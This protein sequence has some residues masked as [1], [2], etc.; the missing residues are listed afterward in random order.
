MRKRALKKRR[1][2]LRELLA[3]RREALG[4]LVLGM[5]VQGVWDDGLLARGAAEVR[6]VEDGLAELDPD[7]E[8]ADSDEEAGAA[9]RPG[10]KDATAETDREPEGRPAEP[11]GDEPPKKRGGRLWGKK[12]NGASDEDASTGQPE[13]GPDS[14]AAPHPEFE[15][16]EHTAEHRLPAESVPTPST[17][18]APE[19][20]ASETTDEGS[21]PAPPQVSGPKD[22]ASEPAGEPSP[23]PPTTSPAEPAKEP[24]IGPDGQ[25]SPEPE[26]TEAGHSAEPVGGTA[27][28]SGP[29]SGSAGPPVVSPGSSRLDALEQRLEREEREARTGVE[30]ARASVG[31]DSG[32]EVASLI[33]TLQKDRQSLDQALGAA[34]QRLSEA[35]RR[36]GE[37]SEKATRLEAESREAAARWVR[38]QAAEIEADAAVAAELTGSS[39]PAPA[40][41]DGRIRELEGEVESLRTQVEEERREKTRAIEAAEARL[42]EIEARA[43][44]VEAG[45]ATE[46]SGPDAAE[47]REAAVTWLRG[48]IVAL[49]REIETGGGSDGGDS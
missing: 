37:A 48:Q 8:S 47:L 44:E 26:V 49:R 16:A 11:E 14:A 7:A 39:G 15:T 3:D 17:A 21:V 19:A 10:P 33:E 34:S 43:A 23:E 45:A 38:E 30:T 27:D 12:S 20:A 41:D 28:A 4:E 18:P 1:E 42:K 35:D 6:E 22:P 40:N 29:P 2:E 9:D 24:S 5:H 31:A 25:G 32:T 46:G 36:A 13:A